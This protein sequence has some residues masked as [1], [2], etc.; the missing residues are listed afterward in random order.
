MTDQ[1]YIV[2]GESGEYSSA[3]SEP[4]G[5]FLLEDDAKNCVIRLDEQC[6]LHKIW[7]DECGK[8]FDAMGGR[9]YTW[10]TSFS[11]PAIREKRDELLALAEQAAGPAPPRESYHE[12]FKYEGVPFNSLR[13][14]PAE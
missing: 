13:A 8:R 2:I 6:R 5:A 1:I 7:R 4:L 12:Y 14:F 9:E 10:T 3:Y 11:E